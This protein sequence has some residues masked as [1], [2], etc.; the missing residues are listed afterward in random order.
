[1]ISRFLSIVA[2]LALAG[3]Q[4]GEQEAGGNDA[5]RG[6]EPAL[7]ALV[8]DGP[9]ARQDQP[10][11]STGEQDDEAAAQIGGAREV[12]V[13]TAT[14]LFEYSWPTEV[15]AIPELA[16][17]LESWLDRNRDSLAR[18]AAQG[19]R[20][21][22]ENGFP[23]NKYSSGTQWKVVANLPDWLSLSATHSVYT[24]GAHPNY[25][26]ETL[27]WDKANRRA[28]QPAMMFVSPEALDAV[29]GRDLCQRLD[30]ERARRRGVRI[31]ELGEGPF[32]QCVSVSETSVLLGSRGGRKFD[33]VGI[34][35]AP[36][37]AGP[38]AEGAY[39]FTFPVT[40]QML[41]AVQPQYHGAFI[42][43]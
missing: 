7:E 3:C 8:P 4:A 43:R 6:D 23:F 27:V 32:G 33:R 24:G 18:E 12:S 9:G 40:K 15:G 21:A 36:Y 16:A 28:L 38:Y 20:A 1:M 35:I 19:Q 17:L 14:Y 2:P 39:E 29:L 5:A 30:K 10:L 13:E 37:I 34:Q 11:P 25:G 41:D 31:D 42:A 26:F 22:R